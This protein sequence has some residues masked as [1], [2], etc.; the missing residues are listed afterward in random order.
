FE[1][2]TAD[3]IENINNITNE[4]IHQESK[5]ILNHSSSSVNALRPVF[6]DFTWKISPDNIVNMA[7]AHNVIFFVTSLEA[8]DCS[9]AE[10]SCAGKTFH[11]TGTNAFSTDHY[12]NIK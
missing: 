3:I 12:F 7:G 5:V 2:L 8:L 6:Q 9:G 11:G 1:Q 10:I 4:K